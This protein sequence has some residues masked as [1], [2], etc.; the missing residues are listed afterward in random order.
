MNRPGA[1]RDFLGAGWKFPLQVNAQGGLA[2][3]RFEQSIEESIYQILG[4]APGE[5]VMLPT[6]GCG[7]HELVFAPNNPATLTLV[8]DSVRRALVTF[9]PRIDVLTVDAEAPEGE[10]NL[11]IIRVDYRVR[12]N[13]TLENLVYP[14]YITEGR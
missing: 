11:L 2:T 4:T 9:E 10:D 6:F 8:I 13:N 12:A 14:F 5:R 3:A 7:M 1:K